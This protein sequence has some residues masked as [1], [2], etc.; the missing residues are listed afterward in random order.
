MPEAPEKEAVSSMKRAQHGKWLQLRKV[1]RRKVT[2][3]RADYWKYQRD[4]QIFIF[5]LCIN[6]NW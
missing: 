6:K 5:R 1:R 4:E 2:L 3:K